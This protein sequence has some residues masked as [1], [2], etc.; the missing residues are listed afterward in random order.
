MSYQEMNKYIEVTNEV[1]DIVNDPNL[2]MSSKIRQLSA[3]N[4]PRGQI[5]KLVNRKYQQV[6][7]IL[8]SPLKKT[9]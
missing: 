4:V 5:A 1:T 3:M 8:N 2:T 6:R 9:S 7:N